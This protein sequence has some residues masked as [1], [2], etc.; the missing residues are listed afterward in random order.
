MVAAEEDDV[1]VADV[2]LL[3]SYQII[4]L[5]Q[6]EKSSQWANFCGEDT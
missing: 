2:L 4:G 3:M 5:P 1:S 6:K